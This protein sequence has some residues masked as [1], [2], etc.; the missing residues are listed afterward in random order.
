MRRFKLLYLSVISL[1]ASLVNGPS[2][3]QSTDSSQTQETFD[4]CFRLDGKTGMWPVSVQPSMGTLLVTAFPQYYSLVTAENCENG[5]DDDCDGLIDE[6]CNQASDPVCTNGILEEGEECDDGNRIN[7][8]GCSNAC[9]IQPYCGNGIVDGL[10]QCD[11]GNRISGDGCSRRCRNEGNVVPARCGDGARNQPSEECDDGN[12]SNS[13]SC[14]NDCKNP[15]CGDGFLQEGVEECEPLIDGEN[16][17]LCDQECRSLVQYN[18]HVR[19]SD[20][21]EIEG[22]RFIQVLPEPSQDTPISSNDQGE[23]QLRLNQKDTRYVYRVERPGY[24]GQVVEIETPKFSTNLDLNVVLK[25]RQ[26]AQVYGIGDNQMQAYAPNTGAS[27]VFESGAFTEPVAEVYVTAVD[28]SSISELAAFPGTFFGTPDDGSPDTAIVSMGVV[29]FSFLNDQQQE[30]NLRPGQTA[31]IRIPIYR[32]ALPEGTPVVE[33]MTIALWS[34]NEDTGIWDQEGTGTVVVDE[35]GRKFL[36]AEVSHFSWWN[37]DIAIETAF[38]E[39]QVDLIGEPLSSVGLVPEDMVAR[40]RAETTEVSRR[41]ASTILELG[42]LS[43]PVY[44]PAIGR[45]V[46]FTAELC[47]RGYPWRCYARSEENC[48]TPEADTTFPV[49]LPITV[50]TPDTL[51]I[52]INPIFGQNFDEDTGILQLVEGDYVWLDFL[53]TELQYQV[54]YEIVEGQLPAG[55]NLNQS[56]TQATIFGHAQSDNQDGDRIVLRASNGQTS[57]DVEITIKI[58]DASTVPLDVSGFVDPINWDLGISPIPDPLVFNLWDS[59]YRGSARDWRNVSGPFLREYDQ[60][61]MERLVPIAGASVVLS[62]AGHVSISGVI[63]DPNVDPLMDSQSVPHGVLVTV[64]AY[65]LVEQ[66]YRTF[67]VYCRI[68]PFA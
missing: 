9:K 24:T 31:T 20:G 34:L 64:E 2:Q 30:I 15:S 27:A 23:V 51:G 52:D 32:E 19:S 8:D 55:L 68:L 25:R 66:R 65:D 45:E 3:A 1:A 53:P 63:D 58:V 5:V 46:C 37:C 38:A 14:T 41:D 61:G 28:V 59:I 26:F 43:D 50:A 39:I 36:E 12:S 62:P 22:A 13:D 6:E 11:D 60:N 4:V 21:F 47:T 57:T 18:I 54:S 16:N 49:N 44:V 10:E 17:E 40:V 67:E 29:E 48:V 33:G 7:S 35:D 56:G 42:E